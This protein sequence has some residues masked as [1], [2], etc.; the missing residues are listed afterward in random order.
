MKNNTIL[1]KVKERLNKIDSQD[2]QNIKPWQILEA[3]NKYQ[4]DWCRENSHGGN[5]Y[6]E[7]DEAST[8]RI[9]DL[10]ILLTPQSL[11]M[12]DKGPYFESLVTDWPVN[13]LRHKRVELYVTKECCKTPK[14]MIVYLGEASNVD[15][16]RRDDHIRPDYA[17]GETFGVIFGNTVKIYHDEFLVDSCSLI[18]YRQPRRVRSVGIQDVYDGTTPVIGE[19]VECEFKEDLA[20]LFCA[21]AAKVLA[22]DDENW[23]QVNRLGTDVEKNN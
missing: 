13:Y 1:I 21:G 16:Y 9:D 2:F 19:E 22:G 4:Y 11:N 6:R 8:S 17:W 14:P 15:I 10:Q 23:Q 5:A 20:E 12:V 18:Y 7:G 3:F